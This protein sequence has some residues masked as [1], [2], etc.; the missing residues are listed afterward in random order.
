MRSRYVRLC[1]VSRL[2]EHMVPMPSYTL[3]PK[4]CREADILRHLILG[5]VFTSALGLPDDEFADLRA[6][7]SV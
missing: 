7:P 6:T 1:E 2:I 5:Y 4:Q 3:A